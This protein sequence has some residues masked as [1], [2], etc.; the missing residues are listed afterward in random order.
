LIRI[1]QNKKPGCSPQTPADLPFLVSLA[2]Q[3]FI[4]TSIRA[5][6]WQIWRVLRCKTPFNPGGF[7]RF[8]KESSDKEIQ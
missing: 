7:D 5:V 2:Y 3:R 6:Q 8:R 1:Y 4:N